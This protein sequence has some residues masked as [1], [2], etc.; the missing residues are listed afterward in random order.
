MSMSIRHSSGTLLRASPPVIRPRLIEGRS[1][2]SEDSRENGSDSM[3]RKVSIALSTALSPI[4]GVDPWAALPA[5]TTRMARTPLAWTPM[6]MSVGSPVM[7]K[8][9]R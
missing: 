4:H 9:A 8:S 1:N 2:S 7:A 6:C 5:T 3:A